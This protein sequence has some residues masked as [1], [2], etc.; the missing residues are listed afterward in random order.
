MRFRGS[1]LAAFALLVAS[2]AARAAG[3]FLPP[4]ERAQFMTGK[5]QQVLGLSE[6][7][8]AK[9][10]AINLEMERKVAEIRARREAS[11]DE[12]AADARDVRK[13]RDTALKGVLDAKQWATFEARRAELADAM[14][15][16][17][18]ERH[19]AAD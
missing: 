12:R 7:Q 15:A 16:W 1:A 19:A 2:L 9:V 17:A 10:A 8:V 18:R 14:K 3:G 11:P 6:T 4:E 5:L 13:D